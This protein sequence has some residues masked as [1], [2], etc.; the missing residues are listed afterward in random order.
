MKDLFDKY[1]IFY[2]DDVALK[3]K[4]SK[5]RSKRLR[6]KLFVDEFSETFVNASYNHSLNL[7]D[8][9]KLLDNLHDAQSGISMTFGG[10]D[11][12]LICGHRRNNL[13]T[14]EETAYNLFKDI[15]EIVDSFRNN[16]WLKELEYGDANYCIDYT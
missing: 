4:A 10:N 11:N 1:A 15:N 12:I 16:F 3:P 7:E 9:D 8:Y 6:K 2:E 5:N 14:Q 13:L